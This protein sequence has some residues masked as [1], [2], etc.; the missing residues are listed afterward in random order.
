L[1]Q[2]SLA[3]LFNFKNLIEEASKGSMFAPQT[4]REETF[5]NL[6]EGIHYATPI[7]PL[8]RKTSEV[9]LVRGVVQMMQGL[10]SSLFYWDQSGQCFCVANVGI[11]VTHLSHSTLHN[12]LSRFTY[13][14]TCLQLVHLRLNLPHS[15]YALPTLRAFASVASH[16]LLVPTT[17]FFSL[18]LFLIN[19]ID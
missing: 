5:R 18:L 9:D 17:F 19:R 2:P 14:A 3:P 15:Y 11:Y 1:K 10:S 8:T 12:L 13:A 16:C 7:I 6:G 4:Q